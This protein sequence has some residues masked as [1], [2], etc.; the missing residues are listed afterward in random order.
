LPTIKQNTNY[1]KIQLGLIAFEALIGAMFLLLMPLEVMDPTIQG[2]GTRQI[3]FFVLFAIFWFFYIFSNI[4]DKKAQKI[5]QWITKKINI[6]WTVFI[7]IVIQAGI[8]Y[9]FIRWNE[10]IRVLMENNTI[11]W[12][13]APLW[14]WLVLFGVHLFLISFRFS[15]KP[16]W[17]INRS[18]P[19]SSTTNK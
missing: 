8:I 7:F 18:H 1:L 6:I 19:G 10:Q 12:A 13:T 2:S 15:A 14:G 17:G 4:N 16:Q 3:G 11:P 9:Y 5:I